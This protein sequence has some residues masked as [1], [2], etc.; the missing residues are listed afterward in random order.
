VSTNGALAHLADNLVVADGLRDGRIVERIARVLAVVPTLGPVSRAWTRLGFEIDEPFEFF[1]CR[2][3]DLRL[4]SGSIRF[5]APDYR[6]RKHTA[7]ASLVDDRLTLGAGLLGW[8]WACASVDRTR[9]LVET[10][11]GC[12]LCEADRSADGVVVL[13]STLSPGATTL[14]EPLT[15]EK[16]GEHPNLVRGLDHVVVD[17]SNS[18]AAANVYAR[19]FGLQPRRRTTADRHCVFMKVGDSVVE[20]V[21]P[22]EPHKGPLTG[23]TWGLA[24]RSQDL[25]ATVST[26]RD[27]SVGIPAP[28]SAIQGGRIVSLPIHLGGVGIVFVGE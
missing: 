23:N 6:R 11:T 26:L 2:A 10:A 16:P 25:D 21:G 14:L 24:F 3:A 17:V 15:D 12:D 13:P 4:E 27:R 1:G 19:A 22:T 9:Y 5:L 7:L 18:N 8:S 28:H 20:L